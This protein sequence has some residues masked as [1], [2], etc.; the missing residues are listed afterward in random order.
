MDLYCVPCKQAFLNEN[1]YFYHKKGKKHIST[2]NKM[3]GQIPTIDVID[4]S[5]FKD[6]AEEEWI[7]RISYCEFIIGEIK[8]LLP[9]VINDTQN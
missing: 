6:E 3:K 5:M 7:K 9:E 2:I 8:N 1:S 4:K